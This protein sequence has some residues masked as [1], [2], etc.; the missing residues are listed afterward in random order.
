[1]TTPSPN[2]PLPRLP[3]RHVAIAT[4][5]SS[6]AL[7]VI[8]MLTAAML[9]SLGSVSSKILLDVFSASQLSLLRSLFTLISLSTIAS[10]YYRDS[11]KITKKEIIPLIGYGVAATVLS[12]FMFLNAIDRVPVGI[13]LIIEYTAPILIV[14]WLR[15]F[16]GIK[17][18]PGILFGMSVCMV[19][20]T[21]VAIPTGGVEIDGIGMAFAFG[22][23][24]ALASGYLLAG[25]ALEKRP[26]TIVSL[27]GFMIGTVAWIITVPA[28]NFPVNLL[29]VDITIPQIPALESVKAF[30]I[31][32][33][34]AI[35]FSVAPALMV[36]Q[37]VKLI[38]P[39]RASAIS[40]SEPV[41]ST[42][43]AWV[44]LSEFL[45]SYQILGGIIAIAGL[46]YL[47]GPWRKPA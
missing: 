17:I 31:V 7:G 4:D 23:A 26:A 45:N 9:H 2:A 15:I 34:I 11:I 43:I 21:L 6:A 37:G 20:L 16:N 42:A 36:L 18:R 46:V 27:F 30:W 39:A 25:K 19:G 8:F 44:I 47:E 32:I 40:M 38:G 28:W 3:K 5:S 10:L 24:V 35:F 13:V 14:F 41:F 1:M 33:L 22:A 12:P 29:F